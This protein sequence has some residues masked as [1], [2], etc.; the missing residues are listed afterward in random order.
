MKQK[1]YFYNSNNIS[2]IDR[3]NDMI[4]NIQECAFTSANDRINI[5]SLSVPLILTRIIWVAAWQVGITVYFK[6]GNNGPED[7]IILKTSSDEM[8][9]S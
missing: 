1:D 4:F 2:W 6:K 3:Q 9:N 8:R 5:S 7:K